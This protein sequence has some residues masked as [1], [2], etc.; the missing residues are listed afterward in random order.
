M[1]TITVVAAS[2]G[3]QQQP[4]PHLDTLSSQQLREWVIQRCRPGGGG[5]RA[6]RAG[7]ARQQRQPAH[8]DTLSPQQIREWIVR[9]GC[10]GGGGYSF[11]GTG[12]RRQQRQQDTFF[13]QRLRDCDSQRGVPGCV[14]AT[15]LGASESAAALGASASTATDPA[16]TEAL[17]TFTLDSGASRCFFRDCTTVTP[18]TAPVPISLAHPTGGLVVARA[19]TVLLC[20]AVPSGSLSGLQLPSF[21]TNLVSNAVVHDVWVD[22]FI[23][24]GQRVAICACSRTRYHLATFT[25]QPGSSLYTLTAASAQVAASGQVAVSSQVSA[26]G[27]FTASC[28]CRVLSHQTLLWHHRLGHLSLP[29]LRGMH[30]HLLVS[31]LPRSLPPLPRSPAPPCLPCV[32]GRQRAAPHSSSFPLTSAPLQTL[33][34]DVKAAVSGVLIPWIHATRHQLRKRFRRELP[35]LRLHSDRG[36]GSLPASLRSSVEARASSSRSRFRPL[37]SKMGLPKTSPTLR[38]MGEVGDASAFRVWGALSLVRDTNASKLSPRTL[39]FLSSQDVTFDESLCFYR[40][41]PHALHLVP[42]PP[43]FVVPI[44][45]P[46]VDPL[47][48]QGPAPS[49]VSQVDPPSSAEPL[50]ISSDSSGPAEGGYPA[51]DNTAATRR[52][53]RLETPLG[54]RP[55]PSS[56]PPQPADVE[57]GAAKGGG[58]GAGASGGAETRGAETGGAETGGADSGG[59]ASPSGGG[60]VGAPA[61]G[62]GVGQPQLP[63]QLE[64]LSPQQ[65]RSAG[66]GGAGGATGGAAGVGVAGAGGTRGFGGAAGTGGA[67]AGGTRGTGAADGTGT[68]PRRPFSTRSRSRP[69]HRLT[70]PFARFLPQLL[71][72]SP[73]PA[74]APHTEVTESVTERREPETRASTPVRARRVA[75]SHPHAVLGTHVMALRPSSVPQCVALPSPLTSSLPDVPDPES[76]LARA[77]S[78]TVFRLLAAFDTDPDFESTAAFALVTELVD[79]AARSRLEYVLSLVTESESVCPPSVGGEPAL[80]SDVLQDTQFELEC[81]AAALPRFASM[82]L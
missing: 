73:L 64:T 21:S 5:Y 8:P 55:R 67:R 71:P 3:G 59:A 74:P 42:S 66:A 38:W 36:V 48:P 47:P 70:Q 68:A 80:S 11:M 79:F 60:A 7:G 18:L 14:E 30:S 52:S 54:F 16:S 61:G 53:P 50:E 58:T 17:Q 25:R 63:S 12:Q 22:T 37:R 39:R 62:L 56:P 31:S 27:Q 26:S 2:R 20:L 76:D 82:L 28:S 77:A 33:H 40:L 51:A 23:P 46:L 10:P 34:M 24:G 6:G 15:A 4:L 1:A 65:I 29:R 69:C 81:L 13:L 9:R 45:P 43:L 32:E 78:P 49:G 44:S 41:H 75:R 57:S 72:G 19:S 35:V